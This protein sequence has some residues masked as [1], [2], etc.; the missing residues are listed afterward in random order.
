VTS[1]TTDDGRAEIKPISIFICSS[2]DMIAERQAALRVIEALNRAAHG[3]ARL[4]PYLWEENIHR[5]QGGQSYQGN[6]PLPAGFDI[7]LGF[8]FSRIGSRLT[9]EEYRRDIATKLANLRERWARDETT[10][11]DLTALTRLTS[12]LP[13]DA[14]PTGTTFEIINAR[15]AAQR[16]GG[17]GRPCLWL[18]VNGAIPKDLNSRD[19]TIAGPI[20]ERWDA[21][22]RFV[23]AELNARHVPVTNYGA[24]VPRAQQEK[25][26]GSQGFEDLLEAWL[27]QTLREQFGVRLTWDQAAYVGLHAFTPE[28]APIFLGRRALIGDALA[29]L[30]ELARDHKITMLL[31]SGPS[32]AGKSSFAQAGLIGNLGTYRLHRRRTEGSLADAALVRTWQ[33]LAV[34]PADLGEDPAIGFLARLGTLLGATAQFEPLI[35]ELAALPFSAAEDAV[36]HDLATRLCAA[37]QRALDSAGAAPALFLV[38]DQLEDLLASNDASPARRLLAMLRALADCPERNVWVVVAIADQW[39]ATLGSAGLVAALEG[40]RQFALPAP[41][42]SELRE[43]IEVPARRAGLVFERAH[44]ESLDSVILDDVGKLSLQ[45]EAPL[46][47][48]Q[49][50]LA[51]LERRRDGNLLTFAAYR[52][53]GGVAGAIRSHARDALADWQTEA[54]RPV[55]DRLLFRLVQRDPQRRIVPRL[56]PRAELEADP[57]MWALTQHLAAEQWRLLQ[58][59]NVAAVAGAMRIAHDVLLGEAE[60]FK[61]FVDDEGDNVILLADARDAAARW[62]ATGGRPGTLLNHH[63]PSVERLQELLVRLGMEAD[64]ELAAFV[65]ASREE[66][67]RLEQERDAA[68]LTRARFLAG[69]A[70][71]CNEASDFGTALALGLEAIPDPGQAIGRVVASEAV[72][73]LDRSV[74][75][76]RER[77][78]LRSS[79]VL[80][81]VW[82]ENAVFD[83]SGTRVLTASSGGTAHLWD[84]ATGAELAVLRGHEGPVSSAVFDLSGARVLTA[85][86]DRTARLWDAARGAELAVLRGHRGAV[87]SVVCDRFGARVL[88]SSEDGT[89]RLWDATTGVELVELR[90]ERWVSSAVFDPFDARVLTASGDGTA[91]LWDTATGAELAVLRGHD[92][93]VR[94]A[95]FDRSG[96]RVL[97]AS[98]DKTA[99]LWHAASGAEL[100]KLRGHYLSVQGA[101][102]D[103]SGTRVLTASED[104]TSRLWDPTSGAEMAVFRGHEGPVTSAVFDPPGTRVLTASEDG[105]S[106]VWDAA[107]GAVL[108]VLRGH[109]RKVSTAVFDVSGASVLTASRDSTARIWDTAS[110]P[111]LAVLRGHT[112]PVSSA[113]FDSSGVRVLTA[114]RDRTARIWDSRSGTQLA[115][116]RGHEGWVS[117]ALFDPSESRVLTASDDGT[118][119]LWDVATG[120]EQA[121][122]RHYKGGINS[123][124]FDSSGMRVLTGSN[125]G[126]AR[127]WDAASGTEVA[128]LKGHKGPVNS[129]IFDP[130]GERVLTASQ[131]STARLWDSASGTELAV[132]SGHKD[133]VLS[134]AFDPSGEQVLT[135][136]GDW[137]ARLWD[138]AT[139]AELVMLRGHGPEHSRAAFD[140]RGAGV[141]AVFD[142]SGTRVLTASEDGTACVWD[143]TTGA[144]LVVLHCPEGPL[145]SAVFD[146]SGTRVLTGF[147]T[148]Q[149]WDVAAG[150]KLAVLGELFGGAV[151]DQ[152]GSRVL[153]ASADG[154]ARIWRVFP[155]V[156]ALVIHARTIRPR[157]L[158]QEQRKQFFLE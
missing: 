11:A 36:P 37:V 70:R 81:W 43:I 130:S 74:R 83:P 100:V 85:S 44:G 10:A 40:A 150:A 6:I 146:P 137:T 122:L 26:G 31:L 89:A 116:L 148:A 15:D 115:V 149:L 38:L 157:A 8:L 59:H 129:A 19:P 68:M 144:K 118:A 97:T 147:G 34:R 79:E 76:I 71:E 28:Q 5:F 158:T 109:G 117:S 65:V 143:A 2:G 102:F 25:P 86:Q 119:R 103:P 112:G 95:V 132:L 55:L 87:T 20:R 114:S 84:A 46:P 21:V 41:R 58:G 107:T 108:T 32:G 134:A 57:E 120:N 13:P 4:E 98:F 138:A 156:E 104:R 111:E 7:F 61:R 123:A 126:T 42:E 139:G 92:G 141:S 78:L 3:A 121:V 133:P 136:S 64:G 48:L 142:P 54:R 153:T 75:T 128:V 155:T 91:R 14:L 154:T 94:S 125:D 106:R 22:S 50:A 72:V 88:T 24:D 96:T 9:D 23:E 60:A 131:D 80:S 77:R 152:S 124:M 18:A 45:A 135:A 73:E 151:F 33:H 66:I 63:L 16:P 113:V 49:V 99:R 17:D 27:T 29:W 47:L 69:S 62:A 127:L 53:M 90:H 39:R 140:R 145:W 30:D 12:D 101:V 67:G 93:A 56:A 35:H 1:D 51:Q 82:I 105:T 110:G 52:E